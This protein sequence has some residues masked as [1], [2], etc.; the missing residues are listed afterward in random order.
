LKAPNGCLRAPNRKLDREINRQFTSVLN[1]RWWRDKAGF[2][3]DWR[4][5]T[6]PVIL[7]RDRVFHVPRLRPDIMIDPTET[8]RTEM[9]GSETTGGASWGGWGGLLACHCPARKLG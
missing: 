2:Y 1:G 3:G 6:V 8:L 7:L 4:H 9:T 5:V